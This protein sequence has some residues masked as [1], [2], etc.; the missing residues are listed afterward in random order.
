MLICREIRS[1]AD[2]NGDGDGRLDL[3]DL[4]SF[5]LVSADLI[6]RHNRGGA[7][8]APPRNNNGPSEVGQRMENYNDNY[9]LKTVVV[10]EESS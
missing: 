4:E 8:P 1:S 3:T 10:N 9:Y 5:A 7:A 6:R 2:R